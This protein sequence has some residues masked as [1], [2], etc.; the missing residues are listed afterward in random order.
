MQPTPGAF[1][2]HVGLITIQ[3]SIGH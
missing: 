1:L 2:A 3:V